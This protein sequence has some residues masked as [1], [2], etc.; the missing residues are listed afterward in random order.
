MRIPVV[1]WNTQTNERTV[2]GYTDTMTD[3]ALPD[4]D[5]DRRIEYY[6]DIKGTTR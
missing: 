6:L 3:Q 1:R 5:D 4:R 2:V